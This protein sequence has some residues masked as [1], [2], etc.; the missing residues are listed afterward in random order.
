MVVSR[1]C[2]PYGR[3]VWLFLTTVSLCSIQ[4]KC[5]WHGFIGTKLVASRLGTKVAGA[6]TTWLGELLAR[7][8]K[9]FGDQFFAGY[10]DLS[11]HFSWNQNRL[12]QPHSPSF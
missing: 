6:A 4:V 5:T 2:V 10:A 1:L 3:V 12:C 8:T 7:Q 11:S 9:A